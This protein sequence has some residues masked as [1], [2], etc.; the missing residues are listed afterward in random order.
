MFAREAA[1]ISRIV[2]DLYGD[3]KPVIAAA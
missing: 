3:A 1:G 2:R